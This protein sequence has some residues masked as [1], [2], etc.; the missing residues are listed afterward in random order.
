MLRISQNKNCGYKTLNSE[1]K[2]RGS[3]LKVDFI[4]PLPHLQVFICTQ[5][6]LN[7]LFLSSI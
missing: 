2:G 5:E 1:G 4:L 3:N 7:F 6:H